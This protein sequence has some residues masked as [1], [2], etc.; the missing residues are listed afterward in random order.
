MP[1]EHANIKMTDEELQ[2]FLGSFSRLIVATVADDGRAWGDAAAYC[3]VDGRVYFRVPQG[4]KSLANIKR[5]DRVCCTVESH[6]TGSSYYAIKGALLYGHAEALAT[7]AGADR[8]RTVLAEI[9][10]PLQPERG[11]DGT[12]FSVGLDD[13]VSF[14]FEKIR[15]RYEDKPVPAVSG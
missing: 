2:S 9:P 4:T 7:G 12:I 11:Q 15:Y 13:V 10:D 1:R 3:F 14:V 8:V 6:P 5:D